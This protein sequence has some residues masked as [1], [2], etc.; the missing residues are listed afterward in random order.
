MRWPIAVILVAGLVACGSPENL[1]DV[2]QSGD[3]SNPP[4]TVAPDA[5]PVEDDID[6]ILQR[7]ATAHYE[8]WGPLPLYHEPGWPTAVPDAGA[9][10]RP[11]GIGPVG[12]EMV[13][14]VW[15]S[16]GSEPGQLNGPH[17]VAIDS[18]GRLLVADAGNSRVQIFDA[19]G[20][21]LG[22][23]GGGAGQ[24]G[25][26]FTAPTDVCVDPA[27]AVYVTDMALNRIQKFDA[28]GGFLFTFSMAAMPDQPTPVGGLGDHLSGPWSLDCS[29]PGAVYVTDTSNWRV[30]RFNSVDGAFERERRVNDYERSY[31]VA[32]ATT[33]DGRLLV[34]DMTNAR[35]MAYGRDGAEIGPF[36]D[37][38]AAGAAGFIPWNI[39]VDAG[40]NV[41]VNDIRHQRVLKL[42][43]DGRLLG[44]L[45]L[46]DIGHGDFYVY[47]LAVAPD[48]ALYLTESN[49]PTVI[50][51]ASA[52][53]TIWRDRQANRVDRI[54]KLVPM[55]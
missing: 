43:P 27:G 41:Y 36:F 42:A 24:G 11:G 13:A 35:I 50:S 16:Y 46:A 48:G 10:P 15:G 49:D 39:V 22:E 19:G 38:Q 4:G 20:V 47:D 28:D 37:A 34:S 52:P 7:T 51:G 17:G 32:V 33:V 45:R 40:G 53:E 14:A 55:R 18:R 12:P 44:E 5:S 9:P 6:A 8:T 25:G 29:Q 26:Q 21:L 31:I 54:V 30:V 2:G 1:D 23:F 3:M